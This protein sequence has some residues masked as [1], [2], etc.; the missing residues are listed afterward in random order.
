MNSSREGAKKDRGCVVFVFHL[1]SSKG[2]S[3]INSNQGQ[4]GKTFTP[5]RESKRDI[6]EVASIVVDRAYGR[7]CKWAWY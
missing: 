6:E 2:K 5:S 7:I 1:D 3:W 4:P